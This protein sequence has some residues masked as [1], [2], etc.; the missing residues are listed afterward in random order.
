MIEGKLVFLPEQIAG[1]GAALGQDGAGMNRLAQSLTDLDSSLSAVWEGEACDRYHRRLTAAAAR[2]GEIAARLSELA[3]QLEKVS[4]IYQE[5]ER[6][7]EAAQA[8]LPVDGI[9]TV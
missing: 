6:K 9:F 2:T 8:G 3:G 5:G 1:V 4:G 7:A